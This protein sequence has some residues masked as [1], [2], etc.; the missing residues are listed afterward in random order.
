MY[1]VY[2]VF[3]AMC[4]CVQPGDVIMFGGIALFCGGTRSKM[5][6]GFVAG[7]VR[8]AFMCRGGGWM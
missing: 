8:R 5:E 7:K 6:Q 1:D 3:E 4:R 2:C